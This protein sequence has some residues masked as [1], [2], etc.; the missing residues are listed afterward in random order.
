MLSITHKSGDTLSIS[1]TWTDSTGLP[2]D[3]AGYTI[4]CQ[5]R[6]STYTDFVDD[7]TTSVVSAPAGTFVISASAS[8][9]ALWPLTSGQY[10]RT[11]CDVQFSK[12]GVVT[13]SDTFEV[14]VVKDITQ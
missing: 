11:Y 13:S 8:A 9:T 2:M 6:D 10:N 12:N 3:L 14:I 4:A 5:V 1:C 7:L